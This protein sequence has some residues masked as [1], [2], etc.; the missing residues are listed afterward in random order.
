LYFGGRIA[1]TT[2]APTTMTATSVA[3]IRMCQRRM[4]SSLCRSSGPGAL[5]RLADV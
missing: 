2:P 1:S 4:R 3:I 5:S